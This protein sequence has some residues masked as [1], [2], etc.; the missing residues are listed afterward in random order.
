MQVAKALFT[1][2]Y[3]YNITIYNTATG[4]LNKDVIIVVWEQYSRLKER[5]MNAWSHLGHFSIW[6]SLPVRNQ[7]YVRLD[8]NLFSLH[9]KAHRHLHSW[10]HHFVR[11]LSLTPHL[12]HL[13]HSTMMHVA[14][15]INSW[16]RV[17]T[18]AA[19]PL[20]KRTYASFRWQ[21][22]NVTTLHTQNRMG[23]AGKKTWWQGGKTTIAE[24]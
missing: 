18:R 12:L 1:I 14:R 9:T 24:Y 10:F 8:R 20:A 19:W 4:M 7:N 22:T 6:P 21:A 17:N 16:E 3:T 15:D 5:S 23:P 11:W 13:I 2:I